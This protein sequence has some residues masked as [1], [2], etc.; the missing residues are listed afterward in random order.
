MERSAKQSPRA[1][2]FIIGAQK[3][4]TTS[5]FASLSTWPG[6]A[7]CE[8]KEPQFFSTVDEWRSN[9]PAYEAQFRG[10][11]LGI[12]ASTSYAF[13]PHRRLRVWDDVHSY[14]PDA[15]IIY[16]VRDP[17]QRIV[18]HYVHVRQR[19]Y[20]E[21]SLEDFTLK[22]SLA[23][24]VSRYALQI[25]PWI[26]RFGASQVLILDF[27]ELVGDHDA[28]LEKVAAFLG[29]ARP[30]NSTSSLERTNTAEQGRVHHRFDRQGRVMKAL[31]AIAPGRARWIRSKLTPKVEKPEV[32]Q[33]LAEAIIRVLETDISEME[34]LTGWDLQHWRSQDA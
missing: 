13:F 34:R 25:R 7:P 6:I 33:E 26:E 14:N 28:S 12:E 30:E 18:S 9:L 20:T 32:P 27:A 8:P 2:A 1:G 19:G 5:L 29:V 24:D 21:K 15:K 22:E 17:V 23:L 16:V 31:S 11:G 4:A 3:C 10:D